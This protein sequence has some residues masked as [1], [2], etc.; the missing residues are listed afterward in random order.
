M[1]A[2]AAG[3]ECRGASCLAVLVQRG[4]PGVLLRGA[5]PRMLEISLGG[6]IYF[7]A[8][9]AA[10]RALGGDESESRERSHHR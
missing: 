7:S 4:G 9:E 3:V 10:K 1:C 6:A 5:A 8:L 2:A